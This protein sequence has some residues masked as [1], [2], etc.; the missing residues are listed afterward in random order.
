LTC[1][2]LFGCR[3]TGRK[4]GDERKKDQIADK[5]TPPCKFVD[6]MFENQ[7]FSI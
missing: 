2:F 6:D 7:I 3:C 5:P 4:G 1:A